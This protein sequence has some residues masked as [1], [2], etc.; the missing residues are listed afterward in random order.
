M[1]YQQQL[2][3]L[4]VVIPALDGDG[5]RSEMDFSDG[6]FVQTLT[7]KKE[8]EFRVD[9]KDMFYSIMSRTILRGFDVNKSTRWSD[10]S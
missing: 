3:R 1:W 5:E 2:E 9:H 10:C 7:L 4:T 8:T 6:V